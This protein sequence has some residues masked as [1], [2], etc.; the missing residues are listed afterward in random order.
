VPQAIK[1]ALWARDGG[2][3]F[4]GCGR[5]RFVDAHHIEHW[6]TGGETSLANLMLLCSKHHTQVHEGGFRIE[7]DY[8]DRWFFRRPDGRAVPACGYRAA[9]TRDDGLAVE[10]EYFAV[11]GSVHT[12]AEVSR[13]AEPS[14]EAYG[15]KRARRQ[16]AHHHP[17]PQ[18]ARMPRACA[19]ATATGRPRHR[20]QAHPGDA[21]AMTVLR[22]LSWNCNPVRP[23]IPPITQPGVQLLA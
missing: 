9:D 14:A 12:S 19:N 8:R 1:R 21:A 7:K 13:V 23:H 11:H 4:P 2:C 6:S 20:Q 18:R 17:S 5:K 16:A 3:R 22:D 10:D 15:A